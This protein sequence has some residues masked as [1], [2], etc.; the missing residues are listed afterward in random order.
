MTTLDNRH[1]Y[2]MAAQQ[3]TSEQV[4]PE[5]TFKEPAGLLFSG[6][7]KITDLDTGEILVEQRSE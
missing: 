4:Q 6:K 2:S 5:D 1:K 3:P 7:V